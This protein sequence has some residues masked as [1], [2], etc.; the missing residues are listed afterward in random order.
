MRQ[1]G[2]VELE[3]GG[4]PAAAAAVVEAEVSSLEKEG[5]RLVAWRRRQVTQVLM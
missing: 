3:F 1:W 5:P 4:V 2:T